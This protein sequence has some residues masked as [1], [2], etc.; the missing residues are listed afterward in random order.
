[1]SDPLV[2]LLG[3]NQCQVGICEE[4]Q[5]RPCAAREA[6]ACGW[7]PLLDLLQSSR[8]GRFHF[9]SRLP[10]VRW[11]AFYTK[12]PDRRTQDVQLLQD[13]QQRVLVVGGS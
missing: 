5:G 3:P 2:R 9:G 1:M 10:T 12:Q 13:D 7:G 8:S 11:R 4:Q 6:M